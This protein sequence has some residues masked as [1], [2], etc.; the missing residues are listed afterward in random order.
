MPDHGD[1]IPPVVDL[2][3]KR[4]PFEGPT[5]GGDFDRVEHNAC[6]PLERIVPGETDEGPAI[7]LAHLARYTFAGK[8]VGDK[9]VLDVA[10]GS[11]YG[12]PILCDAGARSYLGIDVSPEAISLAEARYRVAQRTRFVRDDACC[13][14][15]VPDSSVDTVISFETV[16]HLPDPDRFL[17][18]LR[19][20]LRSRGQLIISTPNRAL[21][22]AANSLVSK[23]TNPFHVREWDQQEFKQLLGQHFEID[24][25]LGQG[26]YPLWKAIV[27]GRAARSHWVR[28]S[29]DLY[30]NGKRTIARLASDPQ[31]FYGRDLQNVRAISRWRVSSYV[32]C[33]ARR[34]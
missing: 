29:V 33:I 23:P 8:Y 5:V 27:L 24:E 21:G 1:P 2:G 4:L 14:S 12:G 10:C 20:V 3:P 16:E 13:L 30:V 19:R 9:D 32:V 7:T 26:S 25:V 28:R 34:R 31:R 11:G 15:T 18:N 6:G 17:S 22:S